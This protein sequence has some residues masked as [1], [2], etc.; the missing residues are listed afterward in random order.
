[1]KAP[2]AVVR[3]FRYRQSSGQGRPRD[4]SLSSL[5]RI[6]QGIL[7]DRFV[8]TLIKTPGHAPA[9]SVALCGGRLNQLQ[10]RRPPIRSA[11]KIDRKRDKKIRMP[12]YSRKL[13][14]G[15]FGFRL[16]ARRGFE[17]SN[18]RPPTSRSGLFPDSADAKR[19]T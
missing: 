3:T 16:Y 9:D 4:R 5:I 19:E 17:I 10:N 6:C 15:S 11:Q 12:S 13:L 7:V 2:V 14:L 18:R 1:M 8:T